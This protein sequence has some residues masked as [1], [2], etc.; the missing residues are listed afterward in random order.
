MDIAILHEG[1]R[2]VRITAKE[3]SS[4]FGARGGRS[5]WLTCPECGQP[6]VTRAMTKHS[7]ISPYFKHENDNPVAWGCPNYRAGS[8]SYTWAE[9]LPLGEPVDL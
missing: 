5:T 3:Y 9:S 7:M 2:K 1:G 4:R 6:V 8:E